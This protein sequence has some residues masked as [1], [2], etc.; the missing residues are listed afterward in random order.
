MAF[1]PGRGFQE[2]LADVHRI[3]DESFIKLT[4]NQ[5]WVLFNFGTAC[6][7]NTAEAKNWEFLAL[8]GCCGALGLRFSTS[9]NAK[10][11]YYSLKPLIS[12]G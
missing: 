5:K 6:L 10:S 12:K 7:G 11:V 2:K 9:D 8:T 1:S 3:S 4:H